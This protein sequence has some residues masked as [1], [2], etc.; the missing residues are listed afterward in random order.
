M[1][2]FEIHIIVAVAAG[3][4]GVVFGIAGERTAFCL[5][6]GIADVLAGGSAPR[7]R[8]W[9]LA[10]AV[11]IAGTQALTLSGTLD[12]SE[13]IYLAGA[14]QLGGVVLGGLMF[15]TGMVLS[16]GCAS[17]LLVLAG[18]GNLRAAMVLI[19][20]GVVAYAT[21]RGL[22]ALPRIAWQDA[23]AFDVA[24]HSVPGL[25]A[26]ATGL[27]L[28][29]VGPSI[30]AAIVIAI[31]AYI[32]ARR[33][34]AR[35]LVGGAVI[36]LLIP[37]GWL[38]TGVLGMDD[39]DPVPLQ[40]LTFTAP[41]ADSVQYFMTFT[42]STINFGIALVAGVLAGSFVSAAIAGR[43]FLIGFEEPEEMLRYLA[44]GALMGIG[45]VVGLGCTI[46]QGLTGVSTLSLAS[47]LTLVSIFAG[48]AVT[49]HLRNRP[50]VR[51]P[52]LTPAE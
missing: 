40:S 23:T 42:G 18:T 45:G 39:F 30:A 33:V 32:F 17:R 35:L 50:P 34:P 19:T 16:G 12:L 10:V 2:G 29:L 36:G 3:L 9:M 14:F 24:S 46:G 43:L 26:K 49:M 1:D 38:V 51:R 21:L 5:R 13:T 31:M 47:I 15:G 6:G 8:A 25:I 44:G 28:E 41:I 11:A 37:A 22:F 20:I 4:L 52:V 48:G 7:L 27:P